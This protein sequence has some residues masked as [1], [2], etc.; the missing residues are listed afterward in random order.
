MTLADAANGTVSEEIFGELLSQIFGAIVSTGD[1]SV[2]FQSGVNPDEGVL[3]ARVPQQG[4]MVANI[5]IRG[6]WTGCVSVVATQQTA[7]KLATLMHGE[8]NPDL[9]DCSDALGE[10]ANIVAGNAKG[11]VEGEN[12]L[13]LPEVEV[14]GVVGVSQENEEIWTWYA[15]LEVGLITVH[16]TFA[17]THNEGDLA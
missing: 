14:G 4:Q 11:L 5:A 7:N 16:M 13:G 2:Q 8:P 17:H 1:H 3:P 12:S 6:D 15:S 10:I 9:E